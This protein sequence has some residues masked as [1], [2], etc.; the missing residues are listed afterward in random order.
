MKKLRPLQL[1][2][3]IFLTVSGGPYGLESLLSYVGSHAALFLLII[4]P[5]LWDIPTI[6]AVMELNSMMPVEGGYYQWVKRAMGLRFA[7]YEGWWTWLYTFADLAIYPVL[8]VEYLGFFFPAAVAVKIPI[9]LSII[10]TCA[11]INIRGILSVGKISILLGL[12]VL[13][14]FLILFLYFLFQHAGSFDLPVP[15]VHGVRLKELGLGLY[16]VMWNFLGWDNIT[17]YA[18]EVSRPVRSYLLSACIAFVLIICVYLVTTFTAIQSGIDFTALAKEGYPA[19]GLSIGGHWLGG[20]I[21]LGGMASGLG[22]YSSVLLSVSKIP[23]VMADDGLLPSVLNKIHS[24]FQTPYVSI[25]TC[26]VVIS[27]MILWTFTHLIIMDVILYGAALFLEFLALLILRK[28]AP[29][30]HRPFKIPLNIYGLCILI[31]L[32]VLVYSVALTGTFSDSGN[33]IYPVL[34]AFGLLISAELIWRIILWKNPDL[35]NTKIQ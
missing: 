7:W 34:F 6:L 32:P 2:A 31:S 4:T 17:T 9:C 23:K 28:T 8:F 10:W 25:I 3:I 5:V 24:R 22:L 12:T 13:L 33:N 15:S 29:D 16:V 20:L 18:D 35:R 27:F 26:S 1:A 14:P 30:D 21:A 19:L 11:F